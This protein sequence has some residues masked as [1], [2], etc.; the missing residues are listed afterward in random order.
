MRDSHSRR[1]LGASL[2]AAMFAQG[3]VEALINGRLIGVVVVGK[4]CL[5][6]LALIPEDSLK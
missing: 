2:Q 5:F 4:Q 1:G 3:K 6:E